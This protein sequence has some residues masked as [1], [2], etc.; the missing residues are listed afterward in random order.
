MTG[1]KD[2]SYTKSGLLLL[3]STFLLLGNVH[4]QYYY[5]YFDRGLTEIHVGAAM[6]MFNFG[7]G[8]GTHLA[9]HANV[10]LN[11]GSSVA[12]F[13]SRQVALEFDFNYNRNGVNTSKLADSYVNADTVINI[14]ATATAGSFQDI[15]GAVGLRFDIA[16]NEY[17]SF[18][19][20][21]SGGL[22]LVYKPEGTINLSTING[23]QKFVETS[24]TQVQFAL[25]SSMG[26]RIKIT[27]QMDVHFAASY[28][29]SKINFEFKRNGSEVIEYTHLGNL[30]FNIGIGY[31]F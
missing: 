12:Y 3:L 16:P 6:P 29:G 17:F 25:Y 20:K 18:V 19:F 31:S 26:A 4:A 30:M 24:D 5:R 28:M 7:S 10:G 11:I 23:T 22:R 1:K 8:N 15:S 27:D 14:S 2:M 9:N 13:Y 21:A